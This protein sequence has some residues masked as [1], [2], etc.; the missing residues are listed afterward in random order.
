MNI[1]VISARLLSRN[2]L[3][4]PQLVVNRSV[5]SS[6]ASYNWKVL[7]LGAGKTTAGRAQEALNA[8][9]YKNVK[10]VG[11]YDTKESDQELVHT[12]KSQQWDAIA[13]G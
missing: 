10:V 4:I 9:G 6:T 8:A 11:I 5:S 2:L 12:L 7:C 3:W 13:I 1:R